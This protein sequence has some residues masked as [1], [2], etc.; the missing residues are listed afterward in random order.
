M[1][2]TSKS[3]QA[4][5]TWLHEWQQHLEW[6]E[7][8]AEELAAAGAGAGKPGLRLLSA[9]TETAMGPL[10]DTV[11][12]GLE[13]G[14]IRVLRSLPVAGAEDPR[15]VLLLQ[16][17]ASAGRWLCLPFGVLS[18]PAHEGEWRTPLA[19]EDPRLAVLCVWNEAEIEGM[20]LEKA[21]LVAR[22]GAVAMADV[23]SV[24]AAWNEGSL[25]PEKVREATGP[26]VV[27]LV[28]PRRD[29]E[30]AVAGALQPWAA[31]RSFSIPKART[32]GYSAAADS[33]LA[34]AASPK[35]GQALGHGYRLGEDGAHLLLTL[36]S[37]LE[38]RLQVVDEA[39]RPSTCLNGGWLLLADG[40]RLPFAG[41]EIRLPVIKL[42][43]GF[44][45]ADANGVLMP[46]RD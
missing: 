6:Q 32:A 11:V 33:T 14:Q 43:D 38:A 12:P 18:E 44:A 4:T 22:L 40:S 5:G 19:E 26:K 41:N 30:A 39:E 42:R 27:H 29:Y 25:M 28:D 21:R 15:P 46:L 9:V 36:S 8:M 10:A 7:A 1:N 2:S 31:L 17:G 20:F 34:L 24:H 3:D 13:S 45:V 16:A 37:P 23:L 35:A